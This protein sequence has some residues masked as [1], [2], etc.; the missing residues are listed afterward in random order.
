MKTQIFTFALAIF[1]LVT[2]KSFA[3]NPLATSNM[4]LTLPAE[5]LYTVENGIENEENLE[6]E[7][8]MTN[9]N[10]WEVEAAVDFS[11]EEVSDEAELEIEEWMINNQL[12]EKAEKET[13]LSVE[14]WMYNDHYWQF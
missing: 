9:E 7:N 11:T 13:P 12:W 3:N 10:L 14:A 5:V 4:N 1:S 6:I 2:V 8:W